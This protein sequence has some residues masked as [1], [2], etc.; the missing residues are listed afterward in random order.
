MLSVAGVHMEPGVLPRD[1]V[2]HGTFKD[3]AVNKRHG[4]IEMSWCEGNK[5]VVESDD[6]DGL[7]LYRI[8]RIE[9]PPHFYVSKPT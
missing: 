8:K 1:S 3:T 4:E 6:S 2:S 7:R 9:Q 5:R